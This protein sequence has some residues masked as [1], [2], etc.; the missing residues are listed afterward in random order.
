MQQPIWDQQLT[1]LKSS[2]QGGRTAVQAGSCGVAML[3][4][5]QGL[6]S[7]LAGETIL[8]GN[9]TFCG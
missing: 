8:G 6:G 2:Q 7:F 3:L 4:I 9:T 1:G 5:L